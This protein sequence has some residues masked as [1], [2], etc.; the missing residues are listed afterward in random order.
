MNSCMNKIK[1]VLI[2]VDNTLLDFNLCSEETI[3]TIFDENGLHCDRY[4]LDTFAEI[5][6]G[7]WARIEQQTLT[8]EELHR[9]RWPLVLDALHIEAD[10]AAFE[11]R[12]LELINVSHV[13]VPG[14]MEL[15]QY[16]APK[17]EV[18]VAS[19]SEY[20]RQYERLELAGMIGYVKDIFASAKLGYPKP[21]KEF[22]DACF[23]ALPGAKLEETV[24]IGD[25][26]AADIRGGRDYGIKT[27]WY[28]HNHQDP[29]GI[30][31]ADVIVDS[32]PE[33][34]DVL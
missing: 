29:V 13:A 8:R 18:Y 9:I 7:L 19:N 31:E 12:F 25:S 16:L 28:N 26:I 34:M 11:K 32:L 24:I 20:D 4:V 15:L 14:A 30:T 3:R 6:H 33:I 23:A 21:S 1:T 27:I 2:D 22:F 5:N 10:G 17:Y